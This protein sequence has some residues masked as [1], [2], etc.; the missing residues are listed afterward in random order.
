MKQKQRAPWA[1]L[2]LTGAMRLGLTEGYLHD[3]E[4]TGQRRRR[5]DDPDLATRRLD[6]SKLRFR[7]QLS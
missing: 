5:D 1:A 3:S 7:A 4:V 2:R 6:P